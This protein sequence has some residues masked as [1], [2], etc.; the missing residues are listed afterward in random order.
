MCAYLNINLTSHFLNAKELGHNDVSKGT[1]YQE[2]K[3]PALHKELEIKIF[4]QMRWL[5]D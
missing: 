3:N 5:T 1:N 4:Y 2:N